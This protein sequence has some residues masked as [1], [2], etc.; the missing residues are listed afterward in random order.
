MQKSTNKLFF[1]KKQISVGGAC[2]PKI[3][4]SD[5][6]ETVYSI[7]RNGLQIT[8]PGNKSTSHELA[9]RSTEFEFFKAMPGLEDPA[10]ETQDDCLLPF[11]GL[12][13]KGEALLIRYL[14][15]EVDP[16]AS[17]P[18]MTLREFHQF[19]RIESY[20]R[21]KMKP[22]FQIVAGAYSS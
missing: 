18:A 7:K 19:A 15:D 21:S 10:Q 16:V 14:C 1:F 11:P 8:K 17:F 22:G 20:T 4:S 2:A 13:E 9:V 3:A 5:R 6:V 12:D